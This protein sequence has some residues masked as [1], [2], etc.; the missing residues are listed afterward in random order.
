MIRAAL[1]DFDMTLIDSSHGVAFCLN[2]VADHFGLR[3]V[4]RSEVLRT[5]GYPMEE[6]MEML[7]GSFQTSWIEY[8]RDHLV[9]S[10]HERLIPFPGV[11]ESLVKLQKMGIRMAVVS[12]RKRLLPAVRVAGLEKYFSQFV[13]MEDIKIPKPDPQSIFFALHKLDVSPECAVFAGDSEVDARA[14]RAAGVRFIGLTTGG[15]SR[16]DLLAE[17]ADF[18]ADDFP[19]IIPLLTEI[20]RG[21][22]SKDDGG[23]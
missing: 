10:E 13:G 3:S 22:K 20:N 18:V 4:T 1:F 12:N 15:R 8:Y 7:W 19:D 2:R 5:I 17:G 11:A 9:T 6:S 21:D 23:A 16:R 14:S